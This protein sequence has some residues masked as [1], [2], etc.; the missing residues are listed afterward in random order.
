MSD[1]PKLPR[2]AIQLTKVDVG[3]VAYS[4]GGFSNPTITPNEAFDLTVVVSKFDPADA[5]LQVSITFAS[6]PEE[7]ENQPF[8]YSLKITVHGEF[9]ADLPKLQESG[10]I[11]GDEEFRKWGSKNGALVLM[12]FLRETV[13]TFTQ[14]TGF[15][16]FIVPMIE[17]AAFQVKPP[18][19][20]KRNDQLETT[21]H[22]KS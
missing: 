15:K 13:H 1:R 18:G 14:K 22:A 16:P 5:T 2:F 6:K 19:S 4:C 8:D 3:E 12:P 11:W 21:A 10:L 7:T 20:A 17:V 9:Q